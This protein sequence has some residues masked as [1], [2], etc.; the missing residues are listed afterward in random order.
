MRHWFT[1]SA[2][3][4]LRGPHGIITSLTSSFSHREIWHLGMNMIAL[5]SFGPRLIDGRSSVQAVSERKQ[6]MPP[7]TP[8]SPFGNSAQTTA[9]PHSRVS[10]MQP[11]LN[12]A[13]FLSFY[14]ASGWLSG[15]AS[16]MFS[17]AV[18]SPTP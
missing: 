9:H 5:V 16:N 4:L 15:M 12:T 11:K 14:V 6:Q 18:R 8:L 7:D 13:E 3:H 17:A 2:V 10:P 1:T